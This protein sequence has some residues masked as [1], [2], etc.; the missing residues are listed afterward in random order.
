[1]I[2]ACLHTAKDLYE[3]RSRY[4]DAS[5]TITAIYSESII[6]SASL[7]RVQDLLLRDAL[8]GRPDLRSAF[9]TA[10]TG[11]MVVFSC[12]DDEVRG[13]VG[14][15]ASGSDL[16]WTDKVKIVWKEDTMKELLQQ[17]RGQQTALLLLIQGLQMES[18]SDIKCLL[19]DNS[20]MLKQIATRS[21][22]LRAYHPRVKVPDSIFGLDHSV[23]SISDSNSIIDQAEFAFDDL[24]VNS[25]A[26]RRAMALAHAK[27]A[28]SRKSTHPV[29][30]DLITFSDSEDPPVEATGLSNT[31]EELQCLDISKATQTPGIQDKNEQDHSSLLNDLERKLLPFMPPLHGVVAPTPLPRKPLL[32]STTVVNKGHEQELHRSQAV[33]DPPHNT[34]DES[35][36]LVEK[37]LL[38]PR[39][40]LF[41][42]GEAKVREILKSKSAAQSAR[43][44]MI[45]DDSSSAFSDPSTISASSINS[46]RT[47]AESVTTLDS[48]RISSG[49]SSNLSEPPYTMKLCA[50]PTLTNA[51]QSYNIFNALNSVAEDVKLVS[52]REIERHNIWRKM[53]Q[54]EI[55]YSQ[56]LDSFRTVFRD[57]IIADWPILAKHLEALDM[58]DDIIEL[59]KDLL[60]RPMQS[61]IDSKAFASC[62]PEIFKD[63]FG[64]A[65]STYRTYHQRYPHAESAIRLTFS[66]D[67]KFRAFL[68]ALSLSMHWLKSTWDTFLK[69]PMSHLEH[70]IT[71]LD[72]L[73]A[74][75]GEGSFSTTEHEYLVCASDNVK[76]LRSTCE[77]LVEKSTHQEEV[78]TL[79]RRIQTLDSSFLERLQLARENRKIIHQGKLAVRVKGKG[80][81]HPVHC[82]LL[83]NYLFWGKVKISKPTT[84]APGGAGKFWVLEA[85]LPIA[86]LSVQLPDKDNQFMKATLIDEV[87]R[88]STLYQV[89]VRSQDCMHT[90][91]AFT[92]QE[93]QPWFD[94]IT[95]A[96]S[97]NRLLAKG[98]T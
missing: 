42:M 34:L 79:Y 6:I 50:T 92:F 48:I 51:K 95:H 3:L 83:D 61:Q 10:L 17:L 7:S 80:S 72:R 9:D 22:S 24:V 63:W 36:S 97:A 67:P 1:M 13:L 16:D 75:E 31:F 5:I 46:P 32:H 73:A 30:G 58:V 4:S 2:A 66:M 44:S 94:S 49:H 45:I 55:R 57:P 68:D 74:I 65:Q 98:Q 54:S 76:S 41:G 90:L 21:R 25:R 87:P 82:V 20:A 28:D 40:S 96:I 14:K 12:L 8:Q 11:C 84:G 88:G 62:S 19:K 37:P 93:R 64:K 70:Y 35:E 27:A 43:L 33:P 81:W 23:T 91:G 15:A 77:A 52:S 78:Q 56:N 89:F 85:P 71:M 59:H 53:I 39:R 29:E 86:E 60:L 47:I 38:P 26:Y 18:L 69:V